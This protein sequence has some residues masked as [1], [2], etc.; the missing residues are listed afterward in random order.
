MIATP[1]SSKSRPGATASSLNPGF[2][3]ATS[4]DSLI[5]QGTSGHSPASI[6][7]IIGAHIDDI[8]ET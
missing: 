6:F 8:L 4:R 3:E 1:A 2:R 7:A 5:W